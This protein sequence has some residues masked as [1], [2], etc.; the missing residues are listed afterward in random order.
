MNANITEKESEPSYF[1]GIGSKGLIFNLY[2]W[3]RNCR[4]SLWGPWDTIGS[5]KNTIPRC[6]SS[7]VCASGPIN[8]IKTN[9]TKQTLLE[10]PDS[11]L[12]CSLKI[13]KDTLDSSEVS[14]NGCL[15]TL[16]SLVCRMHNIR[17]CESS[18]LERSNEFPISYRINRLFII[19]CDRGLKSHGCVDMST[20][21][22]FC[23]LYKIFSVLCL[24]SKQ[25]IRKIFN[26]QSQKIM[27][28]S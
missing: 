18:I 13:S 15:E 14:F 26:L 27:Q 11:M 16:A 10:K 22:H 6:A 19:R 21:H 7:C 23:V 2:A 20:L 3:S 1:W 17:P 28:R 12:H 4:L 25:S 5:Q 8:I 24:R 9:E